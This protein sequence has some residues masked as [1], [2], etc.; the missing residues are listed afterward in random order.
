M[1][2]P[3]GPNFPDP[4]EDPKLAHTALTALAVLV[5][6]CIALSYMLAPQTPLGV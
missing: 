2:T 1:S 5:M 3:T 6:A 4:D